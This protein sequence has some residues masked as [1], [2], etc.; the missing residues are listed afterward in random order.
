MIYDWYKTFN[1]TEFENTG[2]VS[3]EYIYE[4]VGVGEKTILAT[5]GENTSV[6]F[7]DV[8]MCINL[9]DTNPFEFEDRAVYVDEN[10]DVWVGILSDEN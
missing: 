2:L 10:D 7:D 1:K 9:N 3:R 4:F 6:L 5:R 8:F